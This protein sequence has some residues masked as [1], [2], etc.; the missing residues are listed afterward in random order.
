[1]NFSYFRKSTF[2]LDKTVENV[3]KLAEEKGWKILGE[4][5][6]EEGKMVL[7]CKKEWVKTLMKENYELLGFLPCAISVFEKDG[8]LMVGTGQPSVIKALAKTP[9]VALLGQEAEKEVKELVNEAAG[10]GELKP[11]S[12][13][14]Y[15]TM[16]CPYC[17]MEKSWLE[18]KKVEH[19]VVY[20][21]L[22]SDEA[23]KMVDKTG[24]MG[25]PVTE[26]EFE[27][28]EPQYIIGFDKP[29]LSQLL[30]VN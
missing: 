15:S 1:M 26:I 2:S 30:G 20:V 16:S 9:S 6:L 10:V 11:T 24:Q 21:D 19:K 29:T 12:V 25:V 18:E 23:Q 7:V 27:E 13:K 14:L 28:G 17:K 8:N 3:K 4:A 5:D 22:N